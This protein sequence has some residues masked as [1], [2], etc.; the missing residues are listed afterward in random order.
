MSGRPRIP[1]AA[2]RIPMAQATRMQ[3]AP[4]PYRRQ[5]HRAPGDGSSIKRM[6]RF[7]C[8]FSKRFIKGAN[9]PFNYIGEHDA[10]SKGQPACVMK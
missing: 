1:A 8:E 5:G 7:L 10:R 3:Q 2:T 9:V 4:R 6:R